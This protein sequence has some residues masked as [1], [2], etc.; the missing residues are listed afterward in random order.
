[1]RPIRTSM[2]RDAGGGA[3]GTGAGPVPGPSDGACVIAWCNFLYSHARALVASLAP[4]A[5][6]QRLQ[7]PV[8]EQAG[9]DVRLPLVLGRDT[10]ERLR[11]LLLRP[12]CQRGQLPW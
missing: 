11:L 7:S 5:T 4:E 6:Q 9:Q 3:S 8:P 2:V 10:A 12:L 1:M